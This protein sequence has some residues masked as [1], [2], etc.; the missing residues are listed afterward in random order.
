MG[1]IVVTDLLV[2]EQ[3]LDERV[4]FVIDIDFLVR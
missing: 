2:R 1:Q 3:V 4:I